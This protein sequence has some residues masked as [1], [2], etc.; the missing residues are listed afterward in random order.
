LRKSLAARQAAGSR[1]DRLR[2]QHQRA[3]LDAWRGR[4]SMSRLLDRRQ[5]VLFDDVRY[6]RDSNVLD[7]AVM[8]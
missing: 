1:F 4:A 2:Q 3:L 7:G 5:R 8:P 6:G